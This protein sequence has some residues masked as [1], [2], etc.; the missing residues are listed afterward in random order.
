M[1]PDGTNP[2]TNTGASTT[3]G[4]GAAVPPALDFVSSDSATTNLSMA[5]SLA[6]AADNLTSA[7]MAAKELDN[8]S[9]DMGAIGASDP[10]A[11]MER[12]NE[13]LVPAAPVP[14]SIGSVT[15]GPA[16]A[17]TDDTTTPGLGGAT[18]APALGVAPTATTGATEPVTTATSAST[19][20]PA[21]AEPYNPFAA[22]MGAAAPATG[23]SAPAGAAR[24]FSFGAR[25][26]QTSSMNVPAG[27]QPATE[28]FSAKMAGGAKKSNL[29]TVV[30]AILAMV[31][32]VMAIVFAVLWQQAL[33]DEK[34]VYV[35]SSPDE[36]NVSE[37][38]TMMTCTKDLGAQEEAGLIGL[39]S[40]NVTMATSF[41]ND[42]LSAASMVHR[43][44]F[45]DATQAEAA[46]S[47]ADEA[48]AWYAQVA[49]G[50]G[51]APVNSVITVE[52]TTMAL[53][54]EAT[55][56]QLQGDYIAV[57]DLPRSDAGAVNTNRE[58]VQ[59][60]YEGNGYL[61]TED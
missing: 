44:G 16:V 30:L 9:I 29:V 23:T 3:G 32:L 45:G 48:V 17:T 25:P 4:A 49:A 53:N 21:S 60:N 20:A 14:G 40:H 56:A 5:D 57:F 39:T 58:A 46:R 51:I 50:L 31:S 52:N 2:S 36:G 24:P 33:A 6:S 43:Y 11:T 42:Q 26:G 35:P 47:Y 19:P 41:T 8:G 27:S 55:V 15:S 1:N 10:S 61:C 37:V 12:P 54:V 28:K 34:L 18:A 7:G 59:A 22:K 13:P 38:V